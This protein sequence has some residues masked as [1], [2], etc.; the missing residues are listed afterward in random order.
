MAL[1]IETHR[2]RAPIRQL[3][4]WLQPETVQ[5]ASLL[6]L[7]S[8]LSSSP[9]S[10]P[11]PSSP[12]SALEPRRQ[13]ASQVGKSPAHIVDG[14]PAIALGEAGELIALRKECE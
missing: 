5:Q 3:C 9:P 8:S 2:Q 1:A 4:H 11:P 13:R 7:P 14:S 10:L 12:S 6:P